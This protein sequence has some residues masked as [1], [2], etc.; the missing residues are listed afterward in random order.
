M[1]RRFIMT[2]CFIFV[3]KGL[4]AVEKKTAGPMQHGHFGVFDFPLSSELAFVVFL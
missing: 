3:L 2:L 4:P 1:T